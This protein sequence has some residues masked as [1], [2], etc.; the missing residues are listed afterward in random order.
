MNAFFGLDFRMVLLFAWLVTNAIFVPVAVMSSFKIRAVMAESLLQITVAQPDRKKIGRRIIIGYIIQ[1]IVGILF[2]VH[3]FRGP[4]FESHN[5]TGKGPQTGVL[6]LQPPGLVACEECMTMTARERDAKTAHL[7]VHL[8][9][10]IMICGG[11]GAATAAA[12]EATLIWM[13]AV[14]VAG[15]AAASFISLLAGLGASVGCAAVGINEFQTNIET[16]R[17]NYL[18]DLMN[19]NGHFNCGFSVDDKLLRV[20]A[21]PVFVDTVSLHTGQVQNL[22]ELYKKNQTPKLSIVRDTFFGL[23]DSTFFL[24]TG[25]VVHVIFV[26]VG[27]IGSFILQAVLSKLLSNVTVAPPTRKQIVKRIIIGYIIIAIVDILF[28]VLLRGP[29][30]V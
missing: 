29:D 16:A 1:T 30:F 7:T 4:G 21:S 2:Y 8:F 5:P 18:K 6:R 25:F 3:L 22:G 13:N 11:T 14:P 15:T 17:R 10:K 20:R 9:N 28:Y 27:A 24:L 19:C 23:D 12:T 26:P